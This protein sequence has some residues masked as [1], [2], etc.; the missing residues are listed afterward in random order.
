MYF[1]YLSSFIQNQ[2]NFRSTLSGTAGTE[3]SP[4]AGL[5]R[6][7]PRHIRATAIRS[8]TKL[9][10]NTGTERNTRNTRGTLRYMG[11]WYH[12]TDGER[13]GYGVSSESELVWW[14][15]FGYAESAWRRQDLRGEFCWCGG[16]GLDSAES[17]TQRDALRYTHGRHWHQTLASKNPGL[18]RGCVE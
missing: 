17:A 6:A 7:T 14:V 15:R 4:P 12:C 8:S 10:G 5:P 2:L 18:S 11:H 3:N 16:C 1:R 9:L 13:E